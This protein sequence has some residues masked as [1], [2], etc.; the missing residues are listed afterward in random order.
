MLQNNAVDASVLAPRR[1]G[2]TRLRTLDQ[3]DQRTRSARRTREL[4]ALWTKALGGDVSPVQAMAITHAAATQAIAEDLQARRLN[5]DRTITPE[6]IVKVVNIA[7]RA[8][9][10]LGLPE[11][12]S[13]KRESWRRRQGRH[14]RNGNA[15]ASQADTTSCGHGARPRPRRRPRRPPPSRRP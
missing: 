11:Q 8:I 10:A 1:K 7:Q 14:C 13:H 4:I 15:W 6:Q 12:G 3:I 9:R 5:G 2:K